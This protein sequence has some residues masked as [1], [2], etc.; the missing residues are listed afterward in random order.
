VFVCVYFISYLISLISFSSKDENTI[1]SGR[2]LILNILLYPSLLWNL[3]TV[4]GSSS[5][6]DAIIKLETLNLSQT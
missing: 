1:L 4:G 5:T 3:F 2:A 6:D